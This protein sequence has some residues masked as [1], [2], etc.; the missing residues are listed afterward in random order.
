MATANP[1]ATPEASLERSAGS[2]QEYDQTGPL[3]PKGRFGRITYMYWSIVFGFLFMLVA[4]AIIAATG[5][6]PSGDAESLESFT[7]MVNLISILS[8]PITFILAIRRLHDLDWSGWLS[9]LMVVPLANFIMALIL[10]FAGGTQGEN[11][12]GP[13]P[14][15]YTKFQAVIAFLPLVFF[16]IGIVA[17]IAIPAMVAYDAASAGAM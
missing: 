13:P 8:L 1:Y 7:N 6:L 15:P 10:I 17:A 11:K 12:F 16:V 5:A 9:I 2:V 4:G 14:R 3:S